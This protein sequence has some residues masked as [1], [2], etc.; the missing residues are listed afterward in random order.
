MV[1]RVDSFERASWL[2]YKPYIHRVVLGDESRRI[3]QKC[4][5]VLR[6]CGEDTTKMFDRL[7]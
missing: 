5:R 4:A 2:S 1:R 3:A 6:S 7:A